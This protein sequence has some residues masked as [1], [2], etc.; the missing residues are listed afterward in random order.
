MK[1]LSSCYSKHD[2]GIKSVENELNS[3]FMI[4]SSGLFVSLLCGLSES[5]IIKNELYNN[6]NNIKFIKNISFILQS[7]LFPS[8]STSRI[9]LALNL[10]GTS[11]NNNNNVN[12]N[13]KLINNYQ[14]HT[15]GKFRT[16]ISIICFGIIGLNC[17]LAYREGIKFYENGVSNGIAP[18]KLNSNDQ[19]TMII[20]IGNAKE[21]SNILNNNNNNNNNNNKLKQLIPVVYNSDNNIN[22]LFYSIYKASKNFNQSCYYNTITAPDMLKNTLKYNKKIKKIII[23]TSDN[24]L[25]IDESKLIL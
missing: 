25:T 9:Q 14:F 18:I 23:Q 1:D 8:S 3:I 17:S 5:M 7:S 21:I 22:L 20:R 2:A 19:D 10:F 4:G 15:V 11:L 24:T 16:F 13:M 12:N 6:S